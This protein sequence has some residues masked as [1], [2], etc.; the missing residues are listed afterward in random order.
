[1]ALLEEHIELNAVLIELEKSSVLNGHREL[2]EFIRHNPGTSYGI[3]EFILKISERHDINLYFNAIKDLGMEEKIQMYLG[4]NIELPEIKSALNNEEKLDVMLS[5]LSDIQQDEFKKIILCFDDHLEAYRKL[6]LTISEMPLF[7][8]T[9]QTEM[10]ETVENSLKEM[11]MELDKRHPT[12]YAQ[13][14][15]GKNFW[16]ISDWDE[17]EFIPVYFNSPRTIRIFDADKNIL[18]KSVIR[19]EQSGEALKKVLKDKLKL[20]SDPTRLSILRMTYMKPMY[21]KEIADALGL[22]TATV[23]HHLDLMR[24]AGLLNLEQ[25]KHIKYFSTNTR[26][27]NG[28]IQELNMYIKE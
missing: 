25:E 16:N 19:R 3:H 21:G 23:S 14:L 28:L 15:M 2:I 8:K 6:A 5:K 7:I 1:M 27:F 12:S 10:N 20:L 13:S 17:H 24:K 11:K 26:A 4:F 9:L 22:T 18:L